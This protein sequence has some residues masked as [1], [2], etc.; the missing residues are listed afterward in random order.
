[1][2]VE[3]NTLSMDIVIS[4]VFTKVIKTSILLPNQQRRDNGKVK[5]DFRRRREKGKK[6]KKIRQMEYVESIK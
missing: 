3:F 2:R 1:M 6:T 4:R 5:K